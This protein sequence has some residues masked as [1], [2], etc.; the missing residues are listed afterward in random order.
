M[1]SCRTRLC[2]SLTGLALTPLLVAAPL[3]AG[4]LPAAEPA[5]WRQVREQLPP[6]DRLH[7][8]EWIFV[9]AIRN[10]KLEAAEYL[11]DLRRVGDD[12]RF[13]AVLLLRRRDDNTWTVRPIDMRAICSKGSLERIGP[14]GSWMA[15][16]GRPGSVGKVHWICAQP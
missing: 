14:A 11:H 13:K 8:A 9:E 7:S 6:A 15:Y 10:D 16:P 1:F 12:V 4:W 5:V 3:F 2:G